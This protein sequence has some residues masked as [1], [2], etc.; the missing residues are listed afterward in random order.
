M[1]TPSITHRPP[2]VIATTFTAL[3]GALLAVTVDSARA[4]PERLDGRT[5]VEHTVATDRYVERPC[6]ITPPRWNEALDGP[7]PRCRTYVP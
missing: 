3:A 1:N 6:F 5:V 2:V 7:L 4:I